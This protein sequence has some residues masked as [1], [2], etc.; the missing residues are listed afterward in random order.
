MTRM[1]THEAFMV[2]GVL[3]GFHAFYFYINYQWLMPRYYLRHE[4]WRY[5][6]YV[7]AIL[8]ATI[9]INKFILQ[10]YLDFY[11]ADLRPQRQD[12][13]N[14]G[15]AIH[16]RRMVPMVLPMAIV[17]LVS[18]VLRITEHARVREAE[19]NQLRAEHFKAELK[20]LKSQINPH[21]LFNSLNNI[22]SLVV[23][24]S[25]RAPDMLVSLSGMLR[26]MLYECNGDQVPLSKEVA[27]ISNFIALQKLKDD[28]ISDIHFDYQQSDLT[29]SPMILI[30]FVENAFKHGHLESEMGGS[31]S[32][33]LEITDHGLL[34]FSVVNS[35]PNGLVSKDQTGGIGIE[36][37]RKR[38][39]L[40]YPDR[41]DLCLIDDSDKYSVNLKVQLT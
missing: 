27:Y 4:V 7:T 2:S 22:Y 13:I 33:M 39:Q 23:A 14:T 40:L 12:A 35:K 20:H 5:W 15:S 18:T 26:Y 16:I 37:V 1:A 30:P 31:L 21:F 3:V 32:I 41:H 24:K 28:Q 9:V 8:I 36:N 19:T 38:L 10:P 6:M 25:D 34:S 11:P 17:F 29:I